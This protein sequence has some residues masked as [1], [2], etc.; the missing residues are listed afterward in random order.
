MCRHR[1]LVDSQLLVED[2]LGPSVAA[3]GCQAEA[4]I[5]GVHWSGGG[6]WEGGPLHRGGGR[7]PVSVLDPVI[8]LWGE[9]RGLDVAA[10]AGC[11]VQLGG[12][13]R[14]TGIKAGE[15]LT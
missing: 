4:R 13:I 2:L 9:G 12:W 15:R 11:C 1:S 7:R 3:W 6:V 8:Q 10:S 14:S 5:H